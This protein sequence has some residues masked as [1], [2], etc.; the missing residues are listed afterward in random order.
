MTFGGALDPENRWV[1]HSALMPWEELEETF[2]PRFSQSVGAPAKPVRLS[3]GAMF[4]KQRLCL[5]DEE[6]A[7]QIRENAYIQFFMGFAGYSHKEPFDPSMRVHIPKR[8]R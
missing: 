5:A 3:S 7:H 2:A 6:T 8:S 1:L 4:I